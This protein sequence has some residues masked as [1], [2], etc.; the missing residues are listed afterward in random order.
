MFEFPPQTR[1]TPRTTG[2]SVS[3]AAAR[4]GRGFSGRAPTTRTRPGSPC[5]ARPARSPR[6]SS[7]SSH[8]AR[9]PTT[10]LPGISQY[11]KHIFFGKKTPLHCLASKHKVICS[12]ENLYIFP[13]QPAIGVDECFLSRTEE[14]TTIGGGRMSMGLTRTQLSDKTFFCFLFISC[15]QIIMLLF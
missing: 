9:Q 4:G 5:P 13:S 15:Y 12:R 8:S 3:A 7:A 14:V 11:S 1:A 6:P 2:T 10:S